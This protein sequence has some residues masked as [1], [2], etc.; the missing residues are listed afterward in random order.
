MPELWFLVVTPAGEVTPGSTGLADKTADMRRVPVDT[1][2][3]M[4]VPRREALEV[5]L[6]ATVV[7]TV[8]MGV[9]P[10]TYYGTAVFVGQFRD[11]DAPLTGETAEHIRNVVAVV[12]RRN[13]QA[14]K[15]LQEVA[16][17]DVVTNLSR[18]T[19]HMREAWESCSLDSVESFRVDAVR[20]LGDQSELS[21]STLRLADWDEVYRSFKQQS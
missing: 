6:F 17:Q 2:L 8:S 5:N 11:M 15:A 10:E 13:A 18:E 4:Y 12:L 20:W 1:D 3:V 14:E 19:A 7:V 21:S 9:A 16:T